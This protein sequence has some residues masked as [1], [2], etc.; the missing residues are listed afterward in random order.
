VYK[1][2]WFVEDGGGGG[3]IARSTELRTAVSGRILPP[4]MKRSRLREC[5]LSRRERIRCLSETTVVAPGR[6]MSSSRS[7]SEALKRI[8][9]S[10][11]GGAAAAVGMALG[12]LL[13][14]VMLGSLG[15]GSETLFVRWRFQFEVRGLRFVEFEPEFHFRV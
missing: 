1:E 6:G 12:L 5:A 4:C 3:G 9:R 13:G 14:V 11:G 7:G 8:V 2:V 15:L 10:K